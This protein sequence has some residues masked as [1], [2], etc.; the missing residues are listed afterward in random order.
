MASARVGGPAFADFA[1]TAVV[2]AFIYIPT[3]RIRP[4]ILPHRHMKVLQAYSGRP[5][6]DVRL[7]RRADIEIAG[8][9]QGVV[10]GFVAQ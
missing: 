2:S 6:G 4:V 9:V 3:I 8:F 10:P 5:R 7:E 1:R